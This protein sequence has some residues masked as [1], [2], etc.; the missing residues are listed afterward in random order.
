MEN[1]SEVLAALD[2]HLICEIGNE[3]KLHEKSLAKLE[4]GFMLQENVRM[5]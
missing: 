2:P 1:V 5:H 4:K 3:V